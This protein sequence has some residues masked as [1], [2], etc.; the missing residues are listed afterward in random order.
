MDKHVML[1]GM[2]ADNAASLAMHVSLGFQPVAH[3][4]EVGRKF[5]RW[6]DLTFVQ[7]RH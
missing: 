4:R 6:L 2:D 5:D 3:F 7:K 1:G